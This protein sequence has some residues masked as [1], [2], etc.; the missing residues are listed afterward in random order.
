ME[1]KELVYCIDDSEDVLFFLESLL[2][3]SYRVKCFSSA[4]TALIELDSE[5]P[6]VIICD[7][8]M[9]EIDGIEFAKNYREL[10]SYRDT[11][12]IFLSSVDDPEKISSLLADY[13]YD[14]LIK[15]VSEKVL[16]VK[17]EKAIEYVKQKRKSKIS[18][19]LAN[20]DREKILKIL[21]NEFY[22]TQLTLVNNDMYET[23]Q[24]S[25]G[26]LSEE[27]NAKILNSAGKIIFS[28]SP[29]GSDKLYKKSIS[30]SVKMKGLLSKIN[31]KD[32]VITIQTEVANYPYLHIQSIADLG[33]K[34][35]DKLTKKIEDGLEDAKVIKDI[36][37]LHRSLENKI[38]EKI[39]AKI[40]ENKKDG[41]DFNVL[42]EEGF[43][44]YRT[45][46]YK[47]ALELWL[48]AKKIKPDDKILD[49]NIDIL[50]KKL[51]KITNQSSY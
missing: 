3:D 43:E 23:Y 46:H 25:E 33:G 22:N 17:I 41:K 4:K 7:V 5:E 30:S 49:V 1:V 37:E 50:Q 44:L 11:V 9:P 32:K 27:L 36:E 51:D 19:D 20:S 34:I 8:M 13:A 10:Y 48:E 40:S 28:Q 6:E 24:I 42:L 18:I 26:K 21:S 12:I 16:S 15:P 39:T 47:E 45:G 2:K 38:K 35:I 14:Y 31:I 29:V